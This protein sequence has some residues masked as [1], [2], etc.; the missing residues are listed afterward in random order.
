[1]RLSAAPELLKEH[2]FIKKFVDKEIDRA[3]THKVME[4]DVDIDLLNM[5]NLL[6]MLTC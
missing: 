6:N 3:E 1:M 4:A 5:F 2:D